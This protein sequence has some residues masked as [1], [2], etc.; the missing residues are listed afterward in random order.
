VNIVMVKK[1][2]VTHALIQDG[3]T[4]CLKSLLSVNVI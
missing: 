3:V 2:L 4:V 1:E